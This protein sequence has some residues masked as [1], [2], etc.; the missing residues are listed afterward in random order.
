L[1]NEEKFKMANTRELASLLYNFSIDFYTEN[2][3]GLCN[4][5][6]ECNHDCINGIENWLKLKSK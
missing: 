1:T 2:I 6:N 5:C 4:C 3:D